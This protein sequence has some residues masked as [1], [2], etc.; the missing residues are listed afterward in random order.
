MPILKVL[1]NYISSKSDEQYVLEY[2]NRYFIYE[3]TTNIVK[4]IYKVY[5]S[6][7]YIYREE[8]S[9]KI[10]LILEIMMRHLI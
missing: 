4:V 7:T 8:S 9:K 3:N 1:E 2:T 6:K 5:Y 10:K